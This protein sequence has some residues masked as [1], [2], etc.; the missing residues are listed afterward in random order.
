MK[1]ENIGHNNPPK[2][3]EDFY[4]LNKDGESTGRI[5][6]TNTIIKKYLVPIPTD[7]G[8]GYIYQSLN[9]SE[10]IGLRIRLNPG[11]NKTWRYYYKAS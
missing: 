2:S 5:K 7:D 1:K 10:K 3:L 9:D 11:G 6:L 8:E 4:L